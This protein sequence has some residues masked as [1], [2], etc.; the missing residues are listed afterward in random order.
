MKTAIVF[1]VVLLVVPCYAQNS[2]EQ[3]ITEDFRAIEIDGK[4]FVAFDVASAQV[5]LQMRMDYP[6]LELQLVKSKELIEIKDQEIFA[7]GEANTNLNQQ[8]VEFKNQNV[9]LQKQIEKRDSWY[10]SPYLWFT[11]GV[12]AGAALAVGLTYAINE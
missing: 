11:V 6:K 12:V 5:L 10:R 4:P 3:P 7:L 2:A 9:E 8:I 1:F